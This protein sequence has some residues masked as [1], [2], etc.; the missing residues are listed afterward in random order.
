MNRL[1]PGIVLI[2]LVVL[3]TATLVITA[4]E[5]SQLIQDNQSLILKAD[6]LHR[7]HLKAKK[8][9]HHT[10]SILDSLSNTTRR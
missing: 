9:L 7:E 8:K 1:W 4:K 2:T 6:S 10:N 5:N 3:L